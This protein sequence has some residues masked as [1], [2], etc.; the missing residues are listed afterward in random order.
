M[1]TREE[2]IEFL[3][4]L[5]HARES[6]QSLS[7]KINKFFNQKVDLDNVSLLRE[8]ENDDD[9]L[10]DYNLMFNIEDGSDIAGYFDIYML[11]MRRKGFD[12]ADMYITEV[13][14]EFC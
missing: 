9:D 1:K 11:P 5:V 12:G 2:V 3:E 13:G 10:V 4:N 14:Y 7:D 8:Q 6:M